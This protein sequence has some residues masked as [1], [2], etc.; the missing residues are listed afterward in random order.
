MFGRLDLL[1]D[2]PISR[3]DLLLCRNTLMYFNADAQTRILSRFSFSIDTNGFLVLGRAEML[4]SHGAMFAPVDLPAPDISGD[5]QGA[6]I[7]I[8]LDRPGVT[9][10]DAMSNDSR[11]HTRLRLAAFEADSVPQLIVDHAGVL[12]AGQR[13]ARE[14]FGAQRRRYRPA[15]AGTRDLVPAGRPSQRDRSGRAPISARSSS[16]RCITSS[17]DIPA[18]S[19]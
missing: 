12:V 11:P 3:I 18:I 4:F 10:R 5:G 8:G 6:T 19:T 17:A 7:A 2:A 15:V 14:Q 16:R 9:G 13:G 1:Q